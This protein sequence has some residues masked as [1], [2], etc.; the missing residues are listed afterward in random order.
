MSDAFIED[1]V[2]ILRVARFA[3]QFASMGFIVADQTMALMRHMVDTGEVDH[4]VAER[5]WQEMVKALKTKKP[6][7]FFHVLKACHAL[8]VI[9]PDIEKLFHT[10][11]CLD[12]KRTMADDILPLIDEDVTPAIRFAL[13]FSDLSRENEA[14]KD[15]IDHLQQCCQRLRV[16]K[17]WGRLATSVARWHALFP[18]AKQLTVKEL[19]TWLE[20]LDVLRRPEQFKQYLQACQIIAGKKLAKKDVNQLTDYVKRAAAI[21]KAIDLSS[22]QKKG[23]QGLAFANA[24][25]TLREQALEKIKAP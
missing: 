16:P 9:L 6:S 1:P 19:L 12:S 15:D 10:V 25:R 23:L 21:I 20:R 2:R 22:L 3:A 4:L 13:L 8:A 18:R 11:S 17:Q 24:L 5:V 7:V 14:S